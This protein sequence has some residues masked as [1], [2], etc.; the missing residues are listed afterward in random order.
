MSLFFNGASG[1]WTGLFGRSNPV[2]LIV[3]YPFTISC[4]F[5]P[6]DNTTNQQLVILK[7]NTTNDGYFLGVRGDATGDPIYASTWNGTSAQSAELQSVVNFNAW[8]HA[9]ARFVNDTQRVVQIN[10]GAGQ[11]NNV[12]SQ[13]TSQVINTVI[14]GQGDF[15]ARYFRGYIAHVAI[16]NEAI[17]NSVN[18]TLGRGASPLY[19]RRQ[20]L[21]AY[22]PMVNPG[23]Q[24]NLADA[25]GRLPR[26]LPLMPHQQ[27]TTS[28][29]SYSN[30]NPPVKTV[31]PIKRVY[32]FTPPVLTNKLRSQVSFL[33]PYTGILPIA[34][35]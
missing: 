20:N 1:V 21:V 28:A 23:Q 10:G 33:K 4:W 24:I 12:D 16:W 31:L 17:T 35:G 18:A 15:A 25:G 7:N 32:S 14:I 22:W 6:T 29:P 11:S 27:A 26:A 8:N 3:S 30:W 2:N 9:A 13:Q 5:F 34:N 19:I